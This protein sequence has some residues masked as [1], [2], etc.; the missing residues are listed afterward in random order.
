MVLHYVNLDYP[1]FWT[2]KQVLI[3]KFKIIHNEVP[4]PI[5]NVNMELGSMIYFVLSCQFHWRFV[6]CSCTSS[7]RPIVA[8]FVMVSHVLIFDGCSLLILNFPLFK[9]LSDTHFIDFALTI[10]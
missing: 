10:L 9:F 7:F 8:K 2:V 1:Q 3:S 5:P 6:I 4:I